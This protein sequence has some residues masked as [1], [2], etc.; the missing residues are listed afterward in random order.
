MHRHCCLKHADRYDEQLIQQNNGKLD[1]LG[2]EKFY[3][4]NFLL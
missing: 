2:A 1:Y 3:R 4:K